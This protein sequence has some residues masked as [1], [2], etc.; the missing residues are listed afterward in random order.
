MID[1]GL[2]RLSIAA[3]GALLAASC[4][5]TPTTTGQ[6]K[7]VGEACVSDPECSADDGLICFEQVCRQICSTDRDCPKAEACDAVC[8]PVDDPQCT[9]DADCASPPVCRLLAGAACW[10]AACQYLAAPADS[11]CEDGDLCTTGTTCSAA[12]ACGGGGP[13]CLPDSPQCLDSVCRVFAASCAPLSGACS[14]SHEDFDFG[15]PAACAASCAVCEDVVCEEQREGGCLYDGRCDPLSSELPPCGWDAKTDYAPCLLAGSDLGACIAGACLRCPAAPTGLSAAP[16]CGSSLVSTSA[17]PSGVRYFWQGLDSQGTDDGQP[18]VAGTPLPI[19]ASGTYYARSRD[20]ASGCW[21]REATALVVSVLAVPATPPQ[22]LGVTPACGATIIYYETQQA[23]SDYY[24][25][26]NAAGTDTGY[27]GASFLVT[28]SGTYYLRARHQL[29]GCWST[30]ASSL[31]VTIYPV[32][33]Q[34]TGAQA[35]PTAVC[36]GSA[37][38]FTATAPGGATCRWFDAVTDGALLDGDCGY[39][40]T[41]ATTRTV[42]LE[43]FVPETQCASTPR[44]AVTAT[45]KT[46]PAISQQPEASAAC[47]GG[48]YAYFTV[49]ASAT[50]IA[51]QW[52]ERVGTGSWTNLTASS[53]YLGV[54][55]A[56]LMVR[57]Q[58]AW[59]NNRSY[60]VIV[61]GDCTPSV[62]SD[63]A[64]LTIYYDGQSCGDSRT[65]QSGY[66]QLDCRLCGSEECLLQS[67]CDTGVCEGLNDCRDLGTGFQIIC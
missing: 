41:L 10:G 37:V 35:T 18:L 29:S 4:A 22:P 58:A 13:T 3:L 47:A 19:T 38:A 17:P 31:S 26:D 16:G 48:D 43:S 50:G 60:R 49:V 54:T 21:S 36:P 62:T 1:T 63:P 14:S 51:Y 61:S 34:P 46:V 57:P 5:D 40:T 23:L 28:T 56:T 20:D 65:C 12:G 24:W 15:T 66:C 7:G 64:A 59:V 33:A 27:D 42:W 45:A 44:L 11:D 32:P 2:S 39:S 52:Q 67:C 8:M 30:L 9:A 6:G 25:Q 55:S 53:I